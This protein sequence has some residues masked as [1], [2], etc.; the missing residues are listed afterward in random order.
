MKGNP[1]VLSILNQALTT[2]LTS[3]NQFFLHARMFKNWGLEELN[4]KAYKKSIKDMKQADELITRIL[5]L[6]GLPNLQQLGRLQIGEHTEEMLMSDLNFESNQIAEL[7]S[8]IELCEQEKDYVSRELLAS[9]LSY[10]EDYLD[11][12]ETQG[13]LINVTGIENYQQ[14][15]MES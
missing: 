3:I 12:L 7:R 9:I 2:E 4:E 6:E 1:K 13:S 14:S 5:F 10:E 11:W 8:A 15:M